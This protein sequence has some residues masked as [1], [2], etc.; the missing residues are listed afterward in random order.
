MSWRPAGTRY[1]R[2]LRV[3]PVLPVHP[4]E[5]ERE[6]VEKLGKL[7]KSAAFMPSSKEYVGMHGEPSEDALALARVAHQ[8]RLA[9]LEK[10]LD[11]HADRLAEAYRAEDRLTYRLLQLHAP[12]R[13]FETFFTCCGCDFSGFDG[14]APEWPCRT[15]S[16]LM[17][18]L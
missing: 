1:E 13:N 18:G 3:L 7:F 8:R 12:E 4:Q 5:E 10:A 2:D 15:Y 9:E 11:E 14:E 16:L 6:V 17:E